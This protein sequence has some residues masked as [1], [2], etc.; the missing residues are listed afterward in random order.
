MATTAAGTPYVESADLVANYPGTSLS[1]ANRVDQ[2]MQAPT[3]NTI[4][5]T[6]YTAVLLDSGKTV[7]RSNAAASTHTIPAQA[8]VAWGAN[9]QMNVVNLGAG[10]VTITPAGGVTINGAPLTLSTS[11]SGTLV[12]T[13]A[14]VWTLLKT[15]GGGKVLQVVSVTKADSFSTTS[16]SFVDVTGLTA[17]ITPTATSSRI[18]VLG[19]IAANLVVAD[20][21]GY[22]R[23]LRGAT[24]IGGGTVVGSRT[25]AMS[26]LYIVSASSTTDLSV[27]FYDSPASI[28]SQTYKIQA[29]T[30]GNTLA[31]NIAA[32]DGNAAF[33]GR[34]SS[35]ITVMEIG[36]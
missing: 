34:T 19:K 24:V 4:T 31:I 15:G 3:Q 14:N 17:S 35:T 36:A 12:R 16:E 1:L 23:L 11:Q 27:N 32:G 29:R 7:T 30:S 20:T 33:I 9:T 6:T 26:G 18:L 21:Q 2:I 28:S 22:T 10:I 8:T 25:S 5:A 13:A